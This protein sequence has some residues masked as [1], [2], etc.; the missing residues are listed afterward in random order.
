MQQ[1]NFL[2]D[3]V[4]NSYAQIFFSRH[5]HFALTVMAASFLDLWS[6]ISG[7]LAVLIINALALVLGLDKQQIKEGT[8]GFNALLVGLYLGSSFHANIPFFALLFTSCLLTLLFTLAFSKLFARHNIPFL[9][10][11]FTLT[12]WLITLAIRGYSN[13][14]FNETDIYFINRLY[15]LGGTDFVKWY[16]YFNDLPI[17][18][19]WASYLKSLGAILFQHNLIAGFVLAIGLLLH[20][21]I[22]FSLSILG[23]S[24]GYYFYT[25]IGGDLGQVHY[26]Y[27]GFNFILSAIAIGSF[28]LIPSW[29]SYILVVLFTPLIVILISSLSFLLGIYQIPIY[30]LPFFLIV[31]LLLFFLRSRTYYTATE[32]YMLKPV[33]TYI[34]Y[35]SPEKN[36]YHYKNEKERFDN[37][38]YYH[39]GLPF[40]GNW[41]VWQGYNGAYTHKDAWKYA[42]DFVITDAENKTYRNEGKQVTDYYCYN[43][44]VIAPANGYIVNLADNIDE[45]EIGEVYLTSN[46]GN[47]IVIKHDEHFYSQISH[48]KKGSFKVA[49]GEYVYK[50]QVLAN[51]GNSGRSPE[52]HIHFQV[53]IMP[54]IGANPIAYPFNYY[55]KKNREE[56]QK[57]EFCVFKTPQENE[58]VENIILS[59]LL[60]KAFYFAHNHEI[61]LLVHDSKKNDSENFTWQVMINSLN[62]TFLYCPETKSEAYFVN[63]G[64][65]HYFT[66]FFGDKT[67]ALY[68]FYLAAYKVLLGYY[69]DLKIT[70]KL[71]IN[72]LHNSSFIYL[73]DSIAPF[74]LF[75]QKTFSLTYH[76]IDIISAPSEIILKSE[77]HTNIAGYNTETLS[78]QLTLTQKGIEQLVVYQGDRKI[79]MEWETNYQYE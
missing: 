25:I 40:Y 10:L 51:N 37:S 20:S 22:A 13:V 56:S 19:F 66:N 2:F 77:V 1:L 21:R 34:Q 55:I 36:L 42:L 70:D 63:N 64:I 14:L 15:S 39:L 4:L 12:T 79:V 71:P 65:L 31:A 78:F 54:Y 45:N 60:A 49:L 43:L 69:Q 8:Y 6:G 47:S 72:S 33:E 74:Y 24:V 18:I 26:L 41:K 35:Y 5:K 23:F 62:Q 3:F 68:Y 48:I 67:S 75:I 73:Q 76:S 46:W 57:K 61:K 30:A 11:P 50:G 58:Q 27:V 17:P 38:N 52:P 9:S 28:F 44:P 7:L 53:Q 29:S 59:S 32:K 16:K